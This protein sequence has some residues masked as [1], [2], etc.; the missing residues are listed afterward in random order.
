M[1]I[2]HCYVSSPEGIQYLYISYHL[3]QNT[4]RPCF[5]TVLFINALAVCCQRNNTSSVWIEIDRNVPNAEENRGKA[6]FL[7]L[8]IW[9][10]RIFCSVCLQMFV[11]EALNHAVFY[12]EARS[13]QDKTNECKWIQ[14]RQLIK[15]FN[16]TL[17]CLE[18]LWVLESSPGNIS[19]SV[20]I[21]M[22]LGAG[23]FRSVQRCAK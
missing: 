19:E 18:Y 12:Y 9:Q 6:H 20:W 15:I 22:N 13:Y 3:L 5:I 8:K 4:H 7:A 2:F 10:T 11:N 21:I 14:M 16:N 23:N 17:R 1:V